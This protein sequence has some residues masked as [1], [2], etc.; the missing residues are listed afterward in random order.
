MKNENSGA[1]ELKQKKVLGVLFGVIIVVGLYKFFWPSAD[2]SL[3]VPVDNKKKY[4][5]R[6]KQED[7]AKAIAQKAGQTGTQATP[8]TP[9]PASNSGSSDSLLDIERAAWLNPGKLA[10]NRNIFDYPPPPP[11]KPAPPPPPPTLPISRMVPTSIFAG[12]APFELVINGKDFT[13]A[14]RIYLN[15]NAVFAPTNYISGN[16]LRVTVPKQMF[17]TAQSMRVEVKRPGE[18]TAFF[19]NQLT[20]VVNP[21]PEPKFDMIGSSFDNGIEPHAVILDGNDRYY[22]GLEETFGQWKVTNIGTD[23][24]EVEDV[25]TAKGVR[26]RRNLLDSNGNNANRGG[27]YTQAAYNPYQNDEQI[28][29]P[30]AVQQVNNNI[31]NIN[32]PVNDPNKKE[33]T[34]QEKALQQQREALNQRRKELLQQRFGTE[35]APAPNT[36][37]FSGFKP[38]GGVTRGNPNSNGNGGNIPRRPGIPR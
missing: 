17:A 19:S 25:V 16:E 1:K 37:G 35:G 2:L 22:V 32:Q 14:D 27:G 13:K 29:Q 36:G 20:F 38:A 4:E 7:L 30:A 12:T 3:N 9:Q 5:K 21:A 23:Y 15:G 34:P 18:E 26:H 6:V 28:A 10:I 33:A 8:V 11:P 24:V 31:A